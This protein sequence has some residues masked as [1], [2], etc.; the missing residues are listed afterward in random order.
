MLPTTP[1]AIRA[2]FEYHEAHERAA[3]R[4]R[5]RPSM[6]SPAG[7]VARIGVGLLEVEAGARPGRQ[8][9][10]L[11]HPT[12]WEALVRRLPRSGGA[13]ITACSLRRVVVQEHTP[14]LVEGVALLQRGGR[15]EPVAMRLDGALGRWQVVVLQYAAAADAPHRGGVDR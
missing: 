10:P 5:R 7:A 12:L 8:L 14:G 15:V 6:P 1:P 13:A 3:A 9:E 11:C 4:P 2:R